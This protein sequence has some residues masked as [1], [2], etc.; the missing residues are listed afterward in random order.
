MGEADPR[1]PLVP[2]SADRPPTSTRN[3]VV[4]P[5]PLPAD[6]ADAVA[7]VSLEADFLSADTPT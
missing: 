4:L 5:E 2:R 6:E 7:V 3:S 1:S